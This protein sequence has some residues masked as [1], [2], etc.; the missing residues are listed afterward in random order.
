M[1][2]LSI[3]KEGYYMTAIAITLGLLG[4]YW[5]AATNFGA[6]GG[7]EAAAAA[8]A[9]D[10]PTTEADPPAADDAITDGSEFSSG[11]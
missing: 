10:S 9:D 11:K 7:G 1:F 6:E 5:I 3:F 2:I 8:P 4:L